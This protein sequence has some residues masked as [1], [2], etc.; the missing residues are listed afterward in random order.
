[1][2]VK[3][4]IFIKDD[5]FSDYLSDW[6][7]LPSTYVY[8]MNDRIRTPL[9]QIRKVHLSNKLERYIH[10]P[11]KGIWFDTGKLKPVV[12]ADS[13]FVFISDVIMCMKKEFWEKLDR[14]FPQ[15]PKVLIIMD[16]MNAHSF[17]IRYIR[18]SLK[19]VKWDLVLSYD[20]DDCR[21][22][23]FQYLGLTYYSDFPV[24]RENLPVTSDLFFVGMHKDKGEQRDQVIYE[25]YRRCREQ[26]LRCDF[27]LFRGNPGEMPE[28]M[29]GR[30]LPYA[31]V[32]R[33]VSQSNCIL[34]MVQSGQTRQSI[35]Y[36][37]A[38]TMDRK[39]L[40]NN[41]NVRELPYYDPE[42]MKIFSSPEEIDLEWIRE[43]MA[44]GYH[45]QG[46]FSSALISETID[47]HL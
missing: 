26:K 30:R 19:S 13:R 25:I 38:V 29:H 34:E 43:P 15:V 5:S 32:L 6:F 23:G 22:F 40:T 44:E 12:G 31:E 46:E 8:H 18:E 21:E 36:F 2:S 16:S 45:Y 28:G 1:M 24:L 14:D 11:A 10:L 35:R 41:P 37:E 7:C 4:I 27:T 20:L 9:Y 33:R 42:K 17:C 47:R 39:L 3:D